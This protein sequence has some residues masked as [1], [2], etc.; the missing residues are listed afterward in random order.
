MS[1]K[2]EC[3]L[4]VLG[5]ALPPEL[6]ASPL[7]TA[8]ELWPMSRLPELL[9]TGPRS[10]WDGLILLHD[11]PRGDALAAL[12]KLAR[13][14]SRCPRRARCQALGRTRDAMLARRARSIILSLPTRIE[15]LAAAI[16]RIRQLGRRA[17]ENELLASDRRAVVRL[18]RGHHRRKPADAQG[19]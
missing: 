2:A 14:R 9:K 18:V 11:P 15:D 17:A 7:V 16:E 19:L 8:T 1:K 5:Q 13:L 10:D 6:S 4:L 3:R 12:E